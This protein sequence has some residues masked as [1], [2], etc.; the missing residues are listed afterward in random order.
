MPQLPAAAEEMARELTVM[1]TYDDAPDAVRAWLDAVADDVGLVLP[2]GLP[3][4][5]LREMLEAAAPAATRQ[6]APS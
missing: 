2:L 3:E 4:E 5:Q 1:S 6:S